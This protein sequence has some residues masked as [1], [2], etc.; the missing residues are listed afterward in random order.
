MG[1]MRKIKPS[2]GDICSDEVTKFLCFKLP[3]YGRTLILAE[4]G[5]YILDIFI[6]FSDIAE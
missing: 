3:E 2:S 5:V 4:P 1:Y 6:M